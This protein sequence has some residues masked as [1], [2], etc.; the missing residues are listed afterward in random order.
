MMLPLLVAAVLSQ[1][2]VLGD[3]DCD[4]VVAVESLEGVSLKGECKTAGEHRRL[5]FTIENRREASAGT[6]TSIHL[7]FCFK[8]VA[9]ASAPRGWVVSLSADGGGVTF[10]RDGDAPNEPGIRSGRSLGGFVI[11]LLPGW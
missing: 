1:A 4:G 9:R 11:E 5:A 10:S 2:G 8:S 6:L 3:G 7:G